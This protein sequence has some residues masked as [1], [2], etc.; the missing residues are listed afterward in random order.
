MRVLVRATS[1]KRF[2]ELNELLEKKDA[3]V[4][5]RSERRLFVSIENPELALLLDLDKEGFKWE[6]EI[7]HHT[8]EM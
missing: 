3:D 6:K 8:L 1:E 4:K 5:V 2:Q 7:L